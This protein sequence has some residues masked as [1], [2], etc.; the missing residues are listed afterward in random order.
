MFNKYHN[1]TV[2]SIAKPIGGISAEDTTL[3]F[4]EAIRA[5]T[6][7]AP[8]P[9]LLIPGGSFVRFSTPD[10]SHKKNC[11]AKL[12]P[13]G[14]GGVWF[15]WDDQ[16]FSGSWQAYQPQDERQRALFRENMQKA[17]EEATRVDKENRAECRKLS[18]QLLESARTV[19]KNHP[20]VIKKRI[21][22]YGAKQLKQSLLLPV[23]GIDGTLHGLQFIAEDGLKKFKSYTAI[24]GNYLAIGTLKG[25]IIIC[26]GW[27]TGCT[28]HSI[29]GHAVACAFAA[30]NLKPVAVAL[31]AKYPNIEII[32]AADNDFWRKEVAE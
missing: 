13:D 31:R 27:A 17:K 21:T 3:C 18:A 30:M 7:G 15:R 25:K 5:A 8:D 2:T 19:S 24:I 12:F 22:P 4:I 23:R 10:K 29:T 32:V 11:S 14:G 16:N 26:E 1:S 9:S 20:Y 28:L 6:G